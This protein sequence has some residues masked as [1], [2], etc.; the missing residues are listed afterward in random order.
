MST[1]KDE[2]QELFVKWAEASADVL[3]TKRVISAEELITTRPA[4]CMLRHPSPESSADVVVVLNTSDPENLLL[5]SSG[6]KKELTQRSRH[7]PQFMSENGLRTHSI[8]T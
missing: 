6:K 2:I 5:R 1:W 3:Q 8:D 4:S 7:F